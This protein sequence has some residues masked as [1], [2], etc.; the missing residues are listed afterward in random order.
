MSRIVP[1]F[2]R[3]ALQRALYLLILSTF[4]TACLPGFYYVPSSL[5]VRCPVD[6]YQENQG[7]QKCQKCPQKKQTFGKTALT[8][9]TNCS[10]MTKK[11]RLTQLSS[12]ISRFRT[13]PS[14]RT[15]TYF[16]SSLPSTRWKRRPEIRLRWQQE[17]FAGYTTPVTA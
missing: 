12:K 9:K 15:Q 11:K 13:T 10:G 1:Q 7:K 16:R 14:L 5:C 6:T 2:T 8:S 17:W 3:I 4:S